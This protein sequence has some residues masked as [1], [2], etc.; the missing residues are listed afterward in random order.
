MTA[1]VGVTV[2][3][4]SGEAA[5]GVFVSV[6]VG[7]SVGASP[8]EID[9]SC[10]AGAPDSHYHALNSGSEFEPLVETIPVGGVMVTITTGQ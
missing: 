7:V 3:V 5:G 2:T 6:A 4:T 10:W 8:K 1:S 9:R